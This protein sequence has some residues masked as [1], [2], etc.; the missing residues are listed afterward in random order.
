MSCFL[1]YRQ[2][3]LLALVITNQWSNGRF[4]DDGIALHKLSMYRCSAYFWFLSVVCKA[5]DRTGRT[6]HVLIPQLIIC[7][8]KS[9]VKM[10]LECE[11]G[12][13]SCLWDFYIGNWTIKYHCIYR[14]WVERSRCAKCRP[15]GRGELTV[16]PSIVCLTGTKI[17]PSRMS[18]VWD[19][20]PPKTKCSKQSEKSLVW[21]ND[22]QKRYFSTHRHWYDNHL[23]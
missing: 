22:F 11:R 17:V 20:S 9:S 2:E 8:T 5:D 21:I 13:L 1:S 7:R 12:L 6:W 3:F 18:K 14:I 10:C 23:V 16:R 15:F 4:C 19:P